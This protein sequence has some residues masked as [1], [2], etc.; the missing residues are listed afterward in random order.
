MKPHRFIDPKAAKET[1]TYNKE[2]GILTYIK[3]GK[4]VRSPHPGEYVQAKIKDS[5]FAA[6]RIIYVL[7][8]GEQPNVIDHINGLKHD[9]RWVN[10]RNGTRS[11]NQNNQRSHRTKRGDVFLT[12]PG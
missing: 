6:H 3:T 1:F 7:M 8:T 5:L 11:D 10:L 4:P 12:D 9:N 2:T